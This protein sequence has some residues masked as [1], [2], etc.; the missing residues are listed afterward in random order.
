[1]TPPL[2]ENFPRPEQAESLLSNY[3]QGSFA[4]K[5][6]RVIS[7]WREL[8]SPLIFCEQFSVLY[9]LLRALN[10]PGRG[11]LFYPDIDLCLFTFPIRPC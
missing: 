6:P 1:M 4:T 2:W 8:S 3:T 5:Q 10:V 7:F 11:G 9:K